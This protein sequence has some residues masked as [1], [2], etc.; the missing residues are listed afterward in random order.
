[1]EGLKYDAGKL[2]WDLLPEEALEEIVKVFTKGAEKY[3]ERNWEKGITYNRL[4]AAARRHISAFIKGERYD[5]IGTHHI[6]NA[7]VNLIMILQFE[8]ED[9]ADE[10]DTLTKKNQG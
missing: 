9:R 1:M 8:L 2:R 10:L 6:A 4:Y 3:G 5:E 7:I